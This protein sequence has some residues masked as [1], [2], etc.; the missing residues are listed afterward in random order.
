MTVHLIDAQGLSEGQTR[1][2][3]VAQMC[4]SVTGRDTKQ[5]WTS[6]VSTAES[7]SCASSGQIRLWLLVPFLGEVLAECL[8]YSFVEEARQAQ[9]GCAFAKSRFGLR[10]QL[11]RPMS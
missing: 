5:T 8:T 11:R 9:K 2:I 4:K 1:Q 3:P 6:C 10:L 7:G